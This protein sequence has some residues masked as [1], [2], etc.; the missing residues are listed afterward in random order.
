MIRDW[1]NLREQSLRLANE[2]YLLIYGDF[3]SELEEIVL[4]CIDVV[5]QKGH[6]KAVVLINST[7]GAN[8]CYNAIKGALVASGLRTVGYVL[9][10]ALSNAFLTLQLCEK[11]FAIESADLLFHWGWYK[12]GNQELASIVA[13]KTWVL[14]HVISVQMVET[15]MVSKRTGI[16]VKTLMEY[17]LYNRHFTANEGLKLKMIDEIVVAPPTALDL[18]SLNL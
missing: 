2:G 4:E 1:K 14:E 5:K 13:G 17:A 7:G 8:S 15:E 10:Y 12:L 18:S 16:P 9:G 11:R 3:C 6:K